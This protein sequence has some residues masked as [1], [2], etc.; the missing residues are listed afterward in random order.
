MAKNGGT[1]RASFSTRSMMPSNPRPMSTHVTRQDR[2]FPIPATKAVKNAEVPEQKIP[3]APK[4][5][6]GKPVRAQRVPALKLA[7]AKMDTKGFK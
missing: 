3:D 2:I 1:L 5:D 7:G 6:V 4:I